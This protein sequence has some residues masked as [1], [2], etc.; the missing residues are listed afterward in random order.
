MTELKKTTGHPTE[1]LA[2]DIAKFTQD[3]ECLHTTLPLLM[4]VM[5]I[6]QNDTQKKYHDFLEEHSTDKKVDGDQITC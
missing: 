3:I 2:K 1:I 6:V 5:G 4:N